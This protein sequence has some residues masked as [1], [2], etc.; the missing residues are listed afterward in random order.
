[1]AQIGG[2]IINKLKKNVLKILNYLGRDYKTQAT[3][4]SPTDEKTTF[5]INFFALIHPKILLFKGF[6][7]FLPTTMTKYFF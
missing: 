3:D 6:Y 2:K 1:M 4:K 5:L 7:F